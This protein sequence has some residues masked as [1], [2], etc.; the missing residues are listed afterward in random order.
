M[1]FRIESSDLLKSDSRLLQ[2]YRKN[3]KTQ[4]GED[5]VFAEIFNRMGVKHSV[6][7]DVGA[8]DG[9]VFSNSWR[10]INEC[11]WRGVLIE[12]DSDR[13]DALIDCYENNERVSLV[14][15]MVDSTG[16]T[17]DSILSQ[18][19]IPHDFD[20]L[21]I[22]V[23]GIDWHIWESLSGYRPRVVCIEFNPSMQNN[24]HYV[25]DADTS[26]QQGSS[27]RAMIKLGNKKGYELVATTDVNAIFVIR[28]EFAQFGIED[29]SIHSMH[30]PGGYESVLFQFYDGKTMRG[31]QL[32]RIWNLDAKA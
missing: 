26:I 1:E 5:G 7:C 14:G 16:A 17:L 24:V 32:D 9:V 20:F 6:C 10:F 4:F 19:D 2:E 18:L 8:S 30:S 15:A 13:V 31:G 23:D 25:Q 11:G 3:T 22:D 27:L 28:E 21:S 29:N 12:G